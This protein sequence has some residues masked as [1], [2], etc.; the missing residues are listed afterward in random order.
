M[1]RTAE[2]LK[3]DVLGT[4]VTGVTDDGGVDAGLLVVAGEAGGARGHSGHDV[5]V[6]GVAVPGGGVLAV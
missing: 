4:A 1:Y 6:V 2:R 3:T 5:G